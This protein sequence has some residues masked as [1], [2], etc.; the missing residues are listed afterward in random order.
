MDKPAKAK[1]NKVELITEELKRLDV[2]DRLIS[3]TEV[4]N[5]HSWLFTPNIKYGMLTI[6]SFF[7]GTSSTTT[8][9]KRKFPFRL[10]WE[11]RWRIFWA[12]C[13]PH[14]AKEASRRAFETLGF[15][16]KEDGTSRKSEKAW[17]I[18]KK[19][20]WSIAFYSTILISA[21][22]RIMHFRV[23]L[24]A[25]LLRACSPC[26]KNCKFLWYDPAAMEKR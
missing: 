4:S 1:A 10:R 14:F 21:D 19:P 22:V 24:S 6:V 7:N 17:V 18:W 20:K 11:L 9:T 26:T 2:Y 3:A 12:I 8:S 5:C 16:Q 23:N 13:N 25:R 15:W